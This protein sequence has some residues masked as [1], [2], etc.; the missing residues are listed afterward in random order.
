VIRPFAHPRLGGRAARAVHVP[1]DLG[2]PP[3]TRT[4]CSPPATYPN[5]AAGGAGLPRLRRAGER[6]L[7]DTDVVVWF[8]FGTNHV[9]RPE[10]WP[11]MPVHPIG[12][13]LI[14]PA[15]SSAT[16]RWTTPSPA[17]ITAV[18]NHR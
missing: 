11:V 8:T 14:R 15:A 17:T 13:R 10:D 1:P 9:A 16:R 18:E 4:S 5:Q 2:H 7:T 12:F 3:T 6:D